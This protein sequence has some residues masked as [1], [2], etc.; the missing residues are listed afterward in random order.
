M[1]ETVEV[2]RL[3]AHQL[4]LCQAALEQLAETPDVYPPD[5]I[6]SRVAE[7]K[8]TLAMSEVGRQLLSQADTEGSPS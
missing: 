4:L 3:L 7:A 5:V 8:R 6:R 1:D 2:E